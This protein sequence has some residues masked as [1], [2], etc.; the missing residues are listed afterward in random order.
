[1][2]TTLRFRPGL[3]RGPQPCR[4]RRPRGIRLPA[5]TGRPPQRP[6][7]RPHVRHDICCPRPGTTANA[8]PAGAPRLRDNR[9]TTERSTMFTIHNDANATADDQRRYE[10]LMEAAVP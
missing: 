6:A 5:S 3:L 2:K 7:D 8:A 10:R 1:M 4:A 9:P